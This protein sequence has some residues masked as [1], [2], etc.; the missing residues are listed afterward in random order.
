MDVA[1]T[2]SLGLVDWISWLPQ[3][4]TYS[5]VCHKVWHTEQSR[6]N[7]L[8]NM[9]QNKCIG[10]IFTMTA[11]YETATS[12]YEQVTF[13]NS[14]ISKACTTLFPTVRLWYFALWLYSMG[15]AVPLT[16]RMTPFCRKH[17]CSSDFLTATVRVTSRHLKQWNL[18]P[19]N[20][21][22]HLG[23][24]KE[25]SEAPKCIVYNA[26]EAHVESR[27]TVP[28]SPPLSI[29]L[30]TQLLLF[31]SGSRSIFH[32]KTSEEATRLGP[33]CQTSADIQ[34]AEFGFLLLH[35][36]FKG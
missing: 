19:N 25:L 15:T 23:R 34:Q 16:R 9:Q 31:L 36:P 27:K 20:T 29:S 2:T 30:R 5:L 1:D 22:Q 4:A 28:C 10:D 17:L 6:E 33:E 3:T 21:L 12:T 7:S 32:S 24:L 13:I 18:L 11:Q 14:L 8:F 26:S 35:L